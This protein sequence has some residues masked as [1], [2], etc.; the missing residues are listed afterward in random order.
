VQNLQPTFTDTGTTGVTAT[1]TRTQVGYIGK[2][3]KL[4]KARYYVSMTKKAGFKVH[5]A[6]V[7]NG[8]EREKIYLSAYEGSLY[9]VSA[10]A[11]ILDDAQIADFTA[12]TW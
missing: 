5:P 6:F 4:R 11:Y 2:G 3:F 8:V 9:D 10:S 7:Q 1:V 12:S